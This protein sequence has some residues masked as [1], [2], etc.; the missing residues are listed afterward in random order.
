MRSKLACRA[1]VAGLLS[2]GA[3]S[4]AAAD[5]QDLAGQYIFDVSNKALTANLKKRLGK[6]YSA[7]DGRMQTVVPFEGAG[8]Y[9]VSTG[10]MAHNCTIEE[11]FL[12]VEPQTCAVYVGLLREGRP[13][14]YFPKLSSWP[15]P[16]KTQA[17]S[18]SAK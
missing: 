2:I 7:F 14:S 5:C 1:V 3:V 13:I 6:S 4:A 18:W 17:A 11:A 15:A 16:L 9:L 10:C 8:G 12:G